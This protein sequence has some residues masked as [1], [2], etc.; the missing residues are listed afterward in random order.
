MTRH[1]R[2]VVD[3]SGRDWLWMNQRI[4]DSLMKRIVD[5]DVWLKLKYLVSASLAG[6]S[7]RAWWWWCSLTLVESIHFDPLG[8]KIE[9]C[10]T[11]KHDGID[12][13]RFRKIS[14]RMNG[15]SRKSHLFFLPC[16]ERSEWECKF[17]PFI[18]YT[19]ARDWNKKALCRPT[20]TTAHVCLES[21][22]PSV[23]EFAAL[24]TTLRSRFIITLGHV[25]TLLGYQ[26]DLLYKGTATINGTL[27]LSRR[28][29]QLI[30]R[31][32]QQ[33]PQWWRLF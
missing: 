32:Q 3:L 23:L 10:S 31:W 19:R 22:M 5:D 25:L 24:I 6:R 20:T 33:R 11:T 12:C 27:S 30:W 28:G 2:W 8:E 15:I 14:R 13:K 4:D 9:I 18:L 29:L 7:R 1:V 16:Y 17:T 21:C 26:T